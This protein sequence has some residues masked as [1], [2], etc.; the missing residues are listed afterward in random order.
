[1]TPD[2]PPVIGKTRYA[3]LWLNTGH[4]TLG[5]TMG[6]GSGRVLADLLSGRR[7]EIDTRIWHRALRARGLSA[8]RRLSAG[9]GIMRPAKLVIDLAALRH[10]LAEAERRR[11]SREPGSWRW[12]KRTPM[13][14]V[15]PGS[16]PRW[17][18]ADMLGVAC[19][20]EALA[21][22]EAGA[23]QPILLL[24]GVFEAD[25]LPLCARLG[26]EIAVHEPGQLADAGGRPARAAA[27]RLAQGRQ[28]HGPAG[29]PAG[30]RTACWR[31]LHRLR[32]RGA[33]HPPD[34]PFR[35]RRRTRRDRHPRRSRLAALEPPGSR[36]LVLQLGRGARPGPRPMP[37]GCGPGIMLYGVSPMAGRTG[38]EDGLRPVMTLTTRLIAVK[39]VRRGEPV[40]YGGT[41]RPRRHADRH[42]RHRL[43][44]RLSAPRPSGTPVLVGGRPADARR[45]GIDGHAGDRPRPRPRGRRRRRLC[46]SGARPAGRGRRR[47]CRHHRLRA[48]CAGS[49]AASTP[50]SGVSAK[51]TVRRRAWGE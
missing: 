15:L 38:R 5:W 22:R 13:A 7:P 33:R 4:G 23:T 2:G 14:T 6:C 10:N 34:D 25:E 36:A 40:G 46:S 50:S 8:G 49:P 16:C 3:N 44:R 32:R 42:R 21:L 17:P 20:E 48:A 29:L 28:R 11:C 31:R 43:R 35:Q 1:M 39:E 26:F 45:P 19:I 30:G 37:T 9:E 27:R 12:S 47:P 24:E 51:R 41:W 18:A